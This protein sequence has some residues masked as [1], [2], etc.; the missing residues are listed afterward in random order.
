MSQPILSAEGLAK[1]YRIYARPWDR[2]RELA[3]GRPLHQ[4]VRALHDLGFELAAGESLG[5]VGENGAGKSTLLS[6]LAGVTAPSRGS[7]S[8]RGK[9]ASLLELGMGFHPELT[10]RQNILLN[11]AMMGLSEPETRRKIPE[12][13]A[14]AELD[15]FIDRPVKTYSTGMSMRL[16]FAVAVQVEPEI[17]IIDEALS[18][19][20][21]YFQKKCMDRIRAFVDSGRTL[22]LCSHAMYYVSAYCRRAL[23]LR[24]GE[25]AA[26]GEVHEVV[27]RYENFLLDKAKSEPGSGGKDAPGRKLA[28]ITAVR[29]LKEQ[30]SYRYQDPWGLEIEWETTDPRLAFHVGIGI[31]RIDGVQV[32][33]F[34][35]HKDDLPPAVGQERYRVRLHLPELPMLKGEFSLYV[36][37]LGEDGLHVYDQQIL[38]SAFC[39]ETQEYHFS[40]IRVEHSW[41]LP[42]QRETPAPDREAWQASPG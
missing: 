35:T 7:L 38:P 19:G 20:D 10:G 42:E 4:E 17:L 15:A 22:L 12:I 33:T 30:Q 1:V 25:V 32:C 13:V 36:F 11:A 16:G 39:I 37:L 8:V 26:L 27:R 24:D 18:V 3:F 29:Q 28:R 6:I 41:E 31:D 21:G 2:V 23:W 9:V 34:G 14:F 5:I 40:L